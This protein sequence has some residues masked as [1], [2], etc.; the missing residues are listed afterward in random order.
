[1]DSRQDFSHPRP[2]GPGS[3][4]SWA[5]VCGTEPAVGA[6]WGQ[7]VGAVTPELSGL[8]WPAR[9]DRLDLSSPTP[10]SAR[11]S[12]PPKGSPSS[13]H[14]GVYNRCDT[15][16]LNRRDIS[17]MSQLHVKASHTCG[18]SPPEAGSEVATSSARAEGTEATAGHR[19]L[20]LDDLR[21]LC[22]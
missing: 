4:L 10:A 14:F 8:G 6:R 19:S 1:M 11:P 7:T 21:E 16:N 3:G 18:F 15:T 13:Q 2:Q 17:W 12:S 20:D 22:P 5:C 9:G